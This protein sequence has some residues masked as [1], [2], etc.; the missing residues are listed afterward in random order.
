MRCQ[1]CRRRATQAVQAHATAR[2]RH[3]PDHGGSH[4]DSTHRLPRMP[5]DPATRGRPPSRPLGPSDRGHARRRSSRPE[6]KER[7]RALPPDARSRGDG[8]M[9]LCMPWHVHV[10]ASSDDPGETMPVSWATCGMCMCVHVHA[11][12]CAC[13]CELSAGQRVRQRRPPRCKGNKARLL[14][15]MASGGAGCDGRG[16]TEHQGAMRQGEGSCD[17]RCEIRAR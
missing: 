16:R 11:M 17:L 7:R 2:L 14:P 6:R 8:V 3:P 4:A 13:A 15:S 10:H 12:A 5:T 1:H 9:C